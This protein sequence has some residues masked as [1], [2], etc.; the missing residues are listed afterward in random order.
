[1][2]APDTKR[3]RAWVTSQQSM[4]AKARLDITLMCDYIE[5]LTNRPRKEFEEYAGMFGVKA[6]K[7]GTTF[8]YRGK[9]YTVSGISPRSFK[10]PILATS[11]SGKVFKFPASV[12]GGRDLNSFETDPELTAFRKGLV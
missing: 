9:R 6:D 4:P 8:M 1:M 7:F 11:Y 2:K 5:S 12:V 3:I 10:F